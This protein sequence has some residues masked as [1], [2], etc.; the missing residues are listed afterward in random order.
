ML[1]TPWTEAISSIEST[2]PNRGTPC[3][4][5]TPSS[6]T[7]PTTEYPRSGR[8]C[9]RCTNADAWSSV[10]TTKMGRVN[11]P[12]RRSRPNV[13]RTICRTRNHTGST[14]EKMTSAIHRESDDTP[15]AKANATIAT[16]PSNDATTRWR[17][18]SATR[19]FTRAV[20]R[21]LVRAATQNGNDATTTSHSE[22][23]SLLGIG[24]LTTCTPTAN[25]NPMTMAH[26][27]A[28]MT[29]RRSVAGSIDGR[30]CADRSVYAGTGRRCETGTSVSTVFVADR[31]TGAE[32]E[33]TSSSARL[34]APLVPDA[35]RTGARPSSRRQPLCPALA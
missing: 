14:D 33:A 25:A 11:R 12:A 32:H 24:R 21:R 1:L 27:S 15:K 5:S 3:C 17:N 16:T 19:A 35:V 29:R 20:Y 7:N 13:A 4:S 30:C 28:N 22:R 9:T 31:A 18:S 10:P 8:A 6:P 26:T 34:K 23:S 2:S